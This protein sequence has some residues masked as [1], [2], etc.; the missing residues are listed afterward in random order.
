MVL[1]TFPDLQWL[2]KEAEASF[3]SGKNAAGNALQHKGWPTVVLNVSASDV[4]RDNI[5]GPLSVF[6]NLSGE[7]IVEADNRRVKIREGYFFITNPGQH[8]T[9][10][11]G[12]CKS[13]TLNIHFGNYFGRHVYNSQIQTLESLLECG[14]SSVDDPAFHNRLYHRNEKFNALLYDIKSSAND[15]LLLEEKLIEL[16]SVLISENNNDKKLKDQLPAI[17]TSTREEIMKRLLVSVDFI[18]SEYQQSISIDD[19]AATSCLSKFHFLR[20]FKVAFNT[21]PH[22]LLSE[23]RVS[24]AI[25]L[26][27]TTDLPVTDIATQSGFRD[28]SSFSR[29]FQN[30]TGLYPTQYRDLL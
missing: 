14:E 17:K 15:K 20:L 9:L 23:I 21:T 22:Q 29:M 4:H 13:E 7:S 28:A 19:L 16:M 26:L 11:I 18:H 30:Q 5:K 10:D 25:A 6:A 1:H 3:S 8:Y 27:K 12:N 2:K 24:R